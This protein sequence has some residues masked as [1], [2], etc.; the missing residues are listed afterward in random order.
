MRRI[1]TNR[2]C[3]RRMFPRRPCRNSSPPP[4][5]PSVNS[6]PSRPGPARHS[7]RKSKE[8]L[9]LSFMEAHIPTVIET[10]VFPFDELS[11]AAKDRAREWETS[12]KRRLGTE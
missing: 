10:T 7:L 3:R 5:E 2:R 11:D 9:G 6:Y 12:D 4:S 1:R 8:G